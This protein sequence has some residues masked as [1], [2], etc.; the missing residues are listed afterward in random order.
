[1]TVLFSD[2]GNVASDKVGVMKKRNRD[3]VQIRN[4]WKERMKRVIDD[5]EYLFME[6]N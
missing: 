5:S 3:P 6:I 4:L 1:M 2:L